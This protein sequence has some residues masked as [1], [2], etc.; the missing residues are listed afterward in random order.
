[1]HEC[2]HAYAPLPSI[3][4][5]SLGYVLEHPLS[6]PYQARGSLEA[7]RA[8]NEHASSEHLRLYIDASERERQT[9]QEQVKCA[10]ALLKLSRGRPAKKKKRARRQHMQ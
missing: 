4:L 9:L 1:M 10:H 5:I 6:F 2:G 7:M 3:T 8:H